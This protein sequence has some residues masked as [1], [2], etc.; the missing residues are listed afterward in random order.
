MGNLFP[1]PDRIQSYSS[2]WQLSVS[3]PAKSLSS[4]N[5]VF[6]EVVAG[7]PGFHDCDSNLTSGSGTVIIGQTNNHID[8]RGIEGFSAQLKRRQ[9][10][11]YL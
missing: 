7:I 3:H 5:W 11:S 1:L 2:F 6:T 9:L 10:T 8:K 4:E